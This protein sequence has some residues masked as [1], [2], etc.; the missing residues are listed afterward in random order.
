M[1]LWYVGMS[2]LLVA[3]VFWAIAYDTEYALVD[4]EDDVKV[5]IRTSALTFG[6][7]DV[8]AIMMCHGLFLLTM[9]W[10]GKLFRPGWHFYVGVGV[11][12]VLIAFQY[13]MIRTRKPKDCFRAF[14]HNNWV[15]AVI[16]AGIVA[17][18]YL[19]KHI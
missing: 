3:N 2:V 12:A 9:L 4:R 15:G 5:G 13:G 6:R 8:F 16:F 14:G 19:Q 17:S 18:F 1:F 11:A 10:V 7:F